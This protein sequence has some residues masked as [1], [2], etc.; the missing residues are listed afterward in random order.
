MT[1]LDL[2]YVSYNSERW[3]EK[4][5]NSIIESEYDLN[6]VSI[7]V[8][9]NA[10][11]D[12]SVKM[13]C[14]AK[15]RLEKYVKKFE[16]INSNKNLG[17]GKGNNLGFNAGTAPIV[18]FFNIDTELY[19]NTLSELVN[20]IEQ[21]D[22]RYGLWELRQFPYEHPKLYDPLTHE[23][24]WSSGAAFSMRRELFK[25]IHGFDEKIFI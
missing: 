13:L 3:I 14:Q 11:Q 20:D 18:C 19:P 2:I 1:E 25:K 21:S 22:K 17:F 23:T 8:V 7:Y 10:S 9:D 5:F 24:S 4:C 16:V 15:E 12:D 6:Q